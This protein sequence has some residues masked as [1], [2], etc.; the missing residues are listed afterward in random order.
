[1][2]FSFPEES[3]TEQYLVSD[4]T[5]KDKRWWRPER[6]VVVGQRDGAGKDRVIRI[7][8][9]RVSV[10][11]EERD[12]VRLELHKSIFTSV[13]VDIMGCM[14]SIE[15]IVSAEFRVPEGYEIEGVRR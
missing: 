12:D 11:Y 6:I 9:D 8:P 14:Y 2:S 7:P 5:Y 4:I 3:W 15:D 13:C 1:M 10:M